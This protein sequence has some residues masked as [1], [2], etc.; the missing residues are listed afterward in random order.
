MSSTTLVSLAILKVQM[1]R[2]NDYLDHLQPFVLQVLA[3]H[4]ADSITPSFVY[5]SIREQ[6]GLEIPQPTITLVLNRVA[7]R[8]P[9]TKSHGAYRIT[10]TIPDPDLV[11]K[12]ASARRHID[13]V[14]EGLREFSISTAKPLSTN[15]DAVTAIC[16]FFQRFSI[17]CLRSYLRDT[18][19]PTIKRHT[20]SDIVLVANYVQY[21]R[22]TSPERFES[23]LVMLQGHMLANAL[24]RP[25]LS[26]A[27]AHYR[28]V[29]FYFDTPL[30][31]QLLGA[32]GDAKRAAIGDLLTLLHR[33]R[34]RTAA[35]A[36]SLD[37]LHTVLEGAAE[38]VNSPDGRGAVVLEARRRDT[39]R[40]DLLLLSRLAEDRL[41]DLGI[42]VLPTPP[43]ID[44]FQIDEE[45]FERVLDDGVGYWNPR[46]K[47]YDI[48]S[49]RSIF[50]IRGD[51]AARDLERAR[52]VLVTSNSAFAK[53][54]W[55]YGQQYE[56]FHDVSS[57][58]TDFSLANMAWLKVPMGAIGV[59]T[60]QLL[61]YS[62]AALQPS[63]RLL[64]RYMDEID[65]LEARGDVPERALLLL[66]SSPKVYDELTR[67]TLGD[68]GAL[69]EKTLSE[70]HAHIADEVKKEETAKLAAEQ[71]A[72]RRTQEALHEHQ[73]REVQRVETIY[74]RCAN[75]AR[76]L[77]R[78]FWY[79]VGAVCVAGTLGSVGVGTN[80]SIMAAALAISC[81]VLPLVA[82]ANLLTGSTV[83]KWSNR[84]ETWAH[85]WL[86]AREA[87]R[88]GVDLHQFR[89]P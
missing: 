44:T 65:K 69:T 82:L 72:H 75:R 63:R 83:A 19:I 67:L 47:Q 66:R 1:D 58:I 2:G 50:T 73:A 56:G 52:A 86:F 54:A 59:P 5:Q 34:G 78:A 39:S 10:G 60:T 71:R 32:E 25:D 12:Q 27:K 81:L 55:G 11:S 13:A 8:L 43:H 80:N 23:F 14:L 36:H 46:A 6:F 57:V 53:A 21:L 24:T 88:G 15:E 61:S 64:D 77:A 29:I 35:F 62:Y 42:E 30:L 85:E 17:P 70:I 68:D 49:V 51:S 22:R 45:V 37:E 26:T 84:I 4:E 89:A 87:R 41:A 3:D 40:S 33:L 74:W 18:A 16:S 48:D 38:H 76:C 79:S 20:N 31:V 7:R 28:S 9:V